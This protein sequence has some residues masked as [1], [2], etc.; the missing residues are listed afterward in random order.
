MGGSTVDDCDDIA[1][2]RDGNLYLACH[3]DSPDFAGPNDE[4]GTGMDGYV[5]K[6]DPR[7]ERII[8]RVRLAGSNYDAALA[9]AVDSRGH[10]FAVGITKSSDFPTTADSMQAEYGGGEGDAFLVEIGSDGTIMYSSYVGGSAAEHADSLAVGGDGL[11]YFGGAS[12]S[13]NLPGVDP[14]PEP[15]N[16]AESDAFVSAHQTGNAAGLRTM[17]L[18]GSGYDKATEIALDHVGRLYV[19]GFTHSADFPQ[20]GAQGTA[21]QGPSD[22][23]VAQVSIADGTVAFS[24]LIGGSQDDSAWGLA[25]DSHR[26]VY[27]SGQTDSPDFPTT[28]DAFQSDYG[29]RADAFLVRL[30][31]EDAMPRYTTYLGGS[32]EDSAGYDGSA[33]AVDREGNIWLVGFTTSPDFPL[34]NEAQGRSNGD[35]TDG[36]VTV[37]EPGGRMLRWSSYLGG[38]G[39]DLI[40]GLALSP[41]GGAWITGLTAS[42]ALG[43]SPFLQ[44]VHGG[45]RFDAWLARI[46]HE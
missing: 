15:L 18:G 31:N 32:G 34:K 11:V 8:Y 21:L 12:S 4:L 45:G 5:V 9:I 39:R 23:F 10:A 40:E 44:A 37:F 1:L 7:R 28:V 35:E 17:R 25:L 41:D 46:R 24:T 38:E 6:I 26:N 33:L 29:G 36:F 42:E 27:V 30:S 22:A 20:E 14:K 19:A 3:S 16:N 2:G 43:S 13:P